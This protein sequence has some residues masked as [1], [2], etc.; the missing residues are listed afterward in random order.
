MPSVLFSKIFCFIIFYSFSAGN[1]INLFQDKGYIKNNIW[2][3]EDLYSSLA[4]GKTPKELDSL[5]F[6]LRQI[7]FDKNS[8]EA[9]FTSAMESWQMKIS[10]ETGNNM[11]LTGHAGKEKAELKLIRL[12]NKYKLQ[13]KHLS[14]GMTFVPLPEKYNHKNGLAYFVNDTYLSGKYT[15]VEDTTML[16]RFNTDGTVTGIPGYDKY[17][18]PVMCPECPR[19]VN[20]IHFRNTEKKESTVF[21]WERDEGKIVLYKLIPETNDVWDN[22]RYKNSVA[23]EKFLELIRFPN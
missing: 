22:Q 8:S 14:T 4:E 20:I 16:I 10:E 18:I 5:F 23:G 17:S 12:D 3:W 2:I 13:V 7:Y 21:I 6:G 1:Q 11:I 15:S 9:L 19:N